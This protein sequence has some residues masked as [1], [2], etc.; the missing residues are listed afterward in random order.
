MGPRTSRL[1]AACML[2]IAIAVWCGP[3]AGAA[4]TTRPSPTDMRRA[5]TE[6]P[7]SNA[8][9]LYDQRD[10]ATESAIVSMNFWEPDLLLFDSSGSD[11]FVV[12]QG[13]AWTVETVDVSGLYWACQVCGPAHSENVRFYRDAGGRPGRVVAS[14][15][16]LHGTDV[17]GSIGIALGPAAPVLTSG[18]YW[19]AVQVNMSYVEGGEWGW[20]T[21]TVQSNAPAMWQNRRDGFGTGCT[22]WHDMQECLG[23]YG[24]DLAF[25]IEGLRQ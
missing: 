7:S 19:V 23:D 8:D 14:F 5:A 22:R 2:T 25:A 6:A 10:N 20:L 15:R 16:A 17:D 12:P 13:E 11:D 4:T 21:R 1:L 18:T 9:I 3:A 24:P